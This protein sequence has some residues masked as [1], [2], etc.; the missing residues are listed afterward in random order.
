MGGEEGG[1][2][3]QGLSPGAPQEK[4]P[5]GPGKCGRKKRRTGKSTGG[6]ERLVPAILIFDIP[7]GTRAV[8]EKKKRVRYT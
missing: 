4:E 2:G 1:G 6:R 3:C 5:I 7:S 8:L